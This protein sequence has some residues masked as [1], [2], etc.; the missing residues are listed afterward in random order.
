MKKL[1][2]AVAAAVA[3][4]STL[5]N[6]KT[7]C[8]NFKTQSHLRQKYDKTHLRQKMSLFCF[9]SFDEFKVQLN[10]NLFAASFKPRQ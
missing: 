9:I 5:K 2:N 4:A 6:E 3:L 1:K 10:K 7:Q 8:G